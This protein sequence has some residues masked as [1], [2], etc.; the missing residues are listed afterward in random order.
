M[1]EM[2]IDLSKV[3]HKR[4]DVP[5]DGSDILMMVCARDVN[6][7]EFTYFADRAIHGIAD[8]QSFVKDNHILQWCYMNEIFYDRTMED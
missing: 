5:Q 8:W 2:T 6:G 4:K 3:W 7:D 1:E